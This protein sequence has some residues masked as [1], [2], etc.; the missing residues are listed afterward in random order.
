LISR[1]SVVLS[2]TVV[3]QLFYCFP[4]LLFF[5]CFTV[6]ENSSKAVGQQ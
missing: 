2:F 3:L 6:V 4:V 5:S 1:F